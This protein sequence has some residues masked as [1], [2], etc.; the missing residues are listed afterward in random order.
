MIEMAQPGLEVPSHDSPESLIQP[1]GNKYYIGSGESN[2]I[3]LGQP[4]QSIRPVS[5]ASR[6]KALW[7]LA[8]VAI[9][10]LAAAIGAG[11]GA[12]LSTKHKS[13]ESR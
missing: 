12:G 13:S 10:S 11:L 7:A 2:K 5:N 9:L 4:D 3:A 8:V 6:S 1:D